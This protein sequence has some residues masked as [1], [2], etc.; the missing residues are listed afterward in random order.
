MYI[1]NATQS[2]GDIVSIMPKASEVFKEYN[3]DFC[4][5]GNRPLAEAIQK[6]NLNEQEVLKKLDEAY[7]E[8]R[9][10]TNQVDFRKMTLSELINYIV[11]THHVFVKRI[12]PE[13]SEFTTKIVRV[14]GPNHSELFRIHKLFHSL[15]T[16]LDQ[17]LIKEEEIL[18]PMIKEYDLQPSKE[19]LERIG[20]AMKETEDE[21]ET[22]GGVVKEL[23]K[24]TEEYKVPEDGCSTYRM[25][26]EKLQSLE[27]DLF[28]HIHLE[29]N[30]LFKGLGSSGVV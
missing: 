1:F 6:Q 3:I 14:H 29:N 22:A 13:L 19:L 4:C 17:H 7:E 2:I 21:H 25:T 12:L 18:F 11:N 10:F 9:K 8:T 20:T 5:G 23:G 27:A 26:Y 30:I 16:E 28:Q 15:K 24:A